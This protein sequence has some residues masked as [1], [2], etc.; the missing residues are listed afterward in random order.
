MPGATRVESRRV[1]KRCR[2]ARERLLR[3]EAAFDG[4]TGCGYETET[5]DGVLAGDVGALLRDRLKFGAELEEVA[6]GVLIK[7]EATADVGEAGDR[8]KR[9]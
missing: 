6:L 8:E 7:R 4:E 5:L 2:R 3:Q 1:S 9:G